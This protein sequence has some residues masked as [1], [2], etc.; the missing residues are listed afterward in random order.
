MR[1]VFY[2]DLEFG[3]SV[4][5]VPRAIWSENMDGRTQNT[6]IFAA[7]VVGTAKC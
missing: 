4:C 7:S 6:V 3:A 2:V 5:H 1:Y